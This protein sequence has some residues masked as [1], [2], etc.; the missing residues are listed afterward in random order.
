M[1]FVGLKVVPNMNEPTFEIQGPDDDGFVWIC[2]PPGRQMW[3]HN[4]GRTEQAAE[5]MSQW[6]GS[7]EDGERSGTPS[8]ASQPDLR[9]IKQQLAKRARKAARPADHRDEGGQG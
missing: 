7:I 2:S 3:C 6:L 8:A 5:V 4:I 1:Q 9:E